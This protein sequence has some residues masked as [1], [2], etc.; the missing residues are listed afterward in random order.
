[1]FQ[2]FSHLGVKSTILSQTAEKG[3][4]IYIGVPRGG[5]QTVT[6]VVWQSLRKPPQAL[7][8]ET[9]QRGLAE[10]TTSPQA[11]MLQG[12]QVH[13]WQGGGFVVAT[14]AVPL[15]LTPNHPRLHAFSSLFALV[16]FGATRGE[17]SPQMKR[18]CTARRLFDLPCWGLASSTCLSEVE[19][20]WHLLAVLRSPLCLHALNVLLFLAY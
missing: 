7:D 3:T 6:P 9:L 18:Q 17:E 8:R 11:P 13:L 12:W 19:R 5:T 16:F 20:W 2:G 1:M 4:G 15:P 10:K 14:A